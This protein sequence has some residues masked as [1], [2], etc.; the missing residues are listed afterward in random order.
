M[1]TDRYSMNPFAVT[2]WVL[3]LG[4]FIVWFFTQGAASNAYGESQATLA[5]VSTV[6]QSIGL[7]ALTA[8]LILSGLRWLASWW[9]T[10]PQR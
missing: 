2:S 1:T 8:A 4:G 9:R 5:L 10:L 7:A 3:A 6:A